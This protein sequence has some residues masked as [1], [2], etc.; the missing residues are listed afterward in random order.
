MQDL[1]L[2]R[3]SRRRRT[4]WGN[5]ERQVTITHKFCLSDFLC[6]RF[7]FTLPP[8]KDNSLKADRFISPRSKVPAATAPPTGE[9]TRGDP[10][11][12]IRFSAV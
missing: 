7:S 1:L 9:R 10:Q 5:L 6:R 3:P 11:Q 2:V 8:D 4:W 12:R